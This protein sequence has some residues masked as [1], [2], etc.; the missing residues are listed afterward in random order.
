MTVVVDTSGAFAILTG[1]PGGPALA[2]ALE[3]ADRRLMAAATL[4]ELSIVLEGR[5]GP[6]G[7]GIVDRFVRDASIEVVPVDRELA[8]LAVDGWRRFGK[9]RHPAGLNYGDCFAYG[10]AVAAAAPALC[11][12]DGFAATD[13]D[14]VRPRGS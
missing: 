1:E 14:V 6:A 5:H 4:V 13:V 10:L 8:D 7:R 9:G 3:E 11:T 2:A 12:G